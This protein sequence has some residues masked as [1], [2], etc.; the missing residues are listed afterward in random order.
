MLSISVCWRMMTALVEFSVITFLVALFYVVARAKCSLPEP[1]QTSE[2]K[3]IIAIK[4]LIVDSIG[5]EIL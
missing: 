3:N 4:E 1:Q 2:T 5:R